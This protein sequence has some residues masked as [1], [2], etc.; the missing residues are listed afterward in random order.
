MTRPKRGGCTE[1]FSRRGRRSA[2]RSA[3]GPVARGRHRA[4][5]PPI[6]VPRGACAPSQERPP[7]RS[8]IDAFTVA[9]VVRAARHA[10]PRRQALVPRH[11]RIPSTIRMRRVAKHLAEVAPIPQTPQEPG[12]RHLARAAHRA[13]AT[14]TTPQAPGTCHPA[15][16]ATPRPGRD[17][18]LPHLSRS[19]R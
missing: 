8:F 3:V 7:P 11:A 4:G 16:A 15:P 12:T 1:V 17:F 19:R 18:P 13:L 2:R 9:D 5:A 10:I 14:R 6:P